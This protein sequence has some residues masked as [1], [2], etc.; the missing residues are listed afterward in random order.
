MGVG[1]PVRLLSLRW[2]WARS[3]KRLASLGLKSM[4]SQKRSTASLKLSSTKA[5]FA[6]FAISSELAMVRQT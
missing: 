5:S 6:F 2:A 4:A 1:V 3:A